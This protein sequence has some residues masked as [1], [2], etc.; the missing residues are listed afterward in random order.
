MRPTV[1]CVYADGPLLERLEPRLLLDASV[2]GPI[3]SLIDPAT[4]DQLV[5]P[6]GLSQHHLPDVD[7]PASVLLAFVLDGKGSSETAQFDLAPAIAGPGDAALALYDANGNLLMKVDA[8]S[9][10]ATPAVETMSA[11]VKSRQLY[12]LGIF[13]GP[14]P[15]LTDYDLT[16]TVG[17]QAANTAIAVDRATGLGQL[18]AASPEDTFNRPADVDCYELDLLNAGAGGTVTVTPTGQGVQVFATLFRRID[19]SQPWRPVETASDAGGNAV[20]LGLAPLMGRSLT[21]A[22]Y[23]LAVAPVGY[24]TAA[25]S[26]DIDV[27]VGPMLGPTTVEPLAA[28]DLG[29]PPPI[30]PG[31]AEAVAAGTLV[32]GTGE[33]VQFRAPAAG[34]VLL[35]LQTDF[36]PVLSVY[37]ETGADLIAVVS[38][39][40]Q[41][42]VELSLP[43]DAG[44]AYVVRA[45]DVDGNDGGAFE[46][47]VTAAYP[48]QGVVLTGAVTQIDNVPIGADQAASYYR[49]W[50]EHTTD[51]LVIGLAPAAPAGA[52]VVLVAGNLPPVEGEIAPG[53]SL[54]LPVDISG[55]YGPFDLYVAG[56]SAPA[57]ATLRIGQIAVPDEIGMGQL[58]SGKI[59]LAG[60]LAS[61]QAAGAFGDLTGVRYY[62]LLA[63]PGQ[64]TEL[65]AQGTGGAAVL[66]AHYQELGGVLQRTSF[67]LPDESGLAEL[68]RELPAEQ[69]HGIVAMSLG[70]DGVGD[71]QLA[72]DA[73]A[74]MG[75]GV[76]M[77]PDLELGNPPYG[78]VLKIRNI[79][80]EHDFEQHL[81]RTILPFNIEGVPVVTFQPANPELSAAVSVYHA[82]GT[83]IDTDEVN[84]PGQAHSFAL[85]ASIGE[86]MGETLLFRVEPIEGRPLGE[87]EY[88]LTMTVETSNPEP[89][90]LSETAWKFPHTSPH[91]VSG[92][93]SHVGTL[94]DAEEVRDIVQDQFGYGSAEGEFTSSLPYYIGLQGMGNP[95]SIDVY[96]FWAITPG[97]VAVR[98]IPLDERVNTTLKVYRARFKPDGTLD[99]L[100][101]IDGVADNQDWFP[102]DR[103]QIDAQSYINTFEVIDYDDPGSVSDPLYPPD[104]DPYG[105]QGG[106]YFVVVKNE[107]GSQGPYRIEVDVPDFPVEAR[108]LP[109][110]E[111]LPGQPVRVDLSIPEVASITDYV[112]WFPIQVPNHHDGVLDLAAAG[113][114]WDVDVFDADG[115]PLSG[116]VSHFLGTVGFFFLPPGSGTVYMRVRELG[117]NVIAFSTITLSTGLVLPGGISP[118]A[119]T[120]LVRASNM[121][122][123]SPLADGSIGATFD[124]AGRS[125]VYAFQAPI[126][127]LTVNVTPLTVDFEAEDFTSRSS[128]VDPENR[129]VVQDWKIIDAAAGAG[130]VGSGEAAGAPDGQKF[131]HASGDRYVQV[132][133]D[134][135][136]AYHVSDGS[137][138]DA[139]PAVEY[140]FQVPVSGTYN[141]QVCWGGHDGGSNTMFAS[142]VELKDGVGGAAD[143]YRFSHADY[144][145]F[146]AAGYQGAGAFEATSSSG[147]DVGATWDLTAGQTYTLRFTPREDGV[148][149][150]AFRLV[151][152]SDLELR[153]GVYVD[154]ELVV[155]DQTR[156]DAG[157]IV[158]GSMTATL[159]LPG[160]REPVPDP[161][162]AY[163]RESYADV[164]VY[165]Q[166]VAVPPG[167]GEYT[168]SVQS[169]A[170]LPMRDRNLIMDPLLATAEGTVG[171]TGGVTGQAWVRLAVPDY[172]TGDVNLQVGIVSGLHVANTPIRYDLY[173][174]EGDLVSSEMKLTTV[175]VPGSVTFLLAGVVEGNSYYLR[176]GVAN[177]ANT[178]VE[179][180][181]RV[182]LLKPTGVCPQATES[183]PS[184]LF[185][186]EASPDGRFEISFLPILPSVYVGLWV[187][188]GGRAS[189]NVSLGRVS[190][191]CVALYRAV[192]VTVGEFLVQKLQLVDYVNEVDINSFGNFDLEAWLDPGLYV[193]KAAPSNSMGSDV[194]ISG[195]LPDYV[196]E[197]VVLNP[198]DGG[199]SSLPMVNADTA[200]EGGDLEAKAKMDV[201]EHY[202]TRF[203]HVVAPAGSLE[204]MTAEA[205]HVAG[206]SGGRAYFT[207]W[208]PGS[209]GEFDLTSDKYAWPDG[210]INMSANPADDEAMVTVSEAP[211]FEE[212]WVCL[213]RFGLAGTIELWSQFV[214]PFSGTP[215]LVVELI[216]LSPN[217]G[218][219]RVDVTVRN[220]GTGP[221]FSNHA[222]YEYYDDELSQWTS[223]YRKERTLGPRASRTTTFPWPP[224]S[225][226]DD[227]RYL[228]DVD[229]EVEE[230]NERNN[231]LQREL[232]EVDPHSPTL[233]ITLADPNLDGNGTSTD[234]VFG[235]Y[236]SGVL[237][238]T[239]EVLFTGE[240]ADGGLYRMKGRYPQ[241]YMPVES[242]IGE[243]F[244]GGIEGS[245]NVVSFGYDFGNLLPTTPQ[246]TNTFRMTVFDE[247][248]LPSE[249]VVK[250]AEVMP[251]PVW[252]DNE[253]S[254]LTFDR[255]TC[256]YV[257][258]FHNS[259]IHIEGS[260]E[261]LLEYYNYGTGGDIYFIGDLPNV[262]LAEVKANARASLD[263]TAEISAQFSAHAKLTIF[264][265]NIFDETWTSSNPPT[266]DTV[267]FA[268]SLCV[269][270]ETL[271]NDALNLDAMGITFEILNKTLFAE[272][273]EATIFAYGIPGVANINAKL[274]YNLSAVL[275]LKVTVAFPMNP[276]GPPALM[277]P[278]FIGLPFSASCAITGTVEVFGLD[279]AELKGSYAVNLTPAYGLTTPAG[280]LVDFE[281]FFDY[282]DFGLSG[283]MT[284]SIGAYVLGSEVASLSPDPVNIAE[285]GHVVMN[286]AASDEP[287]WRLT[288]YP[289]SDPVGRLLS[290]P[291][292][293]LVIDPAGGEAMYVQV[294]D[295]DPD[296]DVTR[297]NLAFSWRQASVWTALTGIPDA[298]IPDAGSHVS[299]PVLALTHD[300]GLGVCP[301]V[302]VYLALAAENDPADRTRNQFFAGQDIR[303]RYFDGSTWQAEHSLT[304]DG[305]YDSE[306]AV[307]FNSTGAGVAAWT[308][309]TNPAPIG[310]DGVFDR[311]ANEIQVAAWDPAGHAWTATQTLTADAVADGMPAA[312]A[313]E[314]GTLYVV[315]LRDTTGGNEI[316]YST[317]SGGGWSPPA[318][319]PVTALPEGGRISSVAI[320]SRGPGRIDVL[321]AH[322]RQFEDYSVES[323]LYNRPSTAADF[324]LPTALEIV[325][326]NANFSHL[327]TVRA[328]DD[329]ALVAYWQQSDGVTTEVF[330]SRVGPSPAGPATWSEPIRLTSGENIEVTPSVAV[331]TDGTYQVVYE[332]QATPVPLGLSSQADPAVGVPTAG[333]VGTSH[334]ELLPELG[335]LREM[336]FPYATKAASGAECVATARI[337]NRGPAGDSVLIEYIEYRAAAGGPVVVGSETILL[338]PG[339]E[340]EIAHPFTVAAGLV[341]YSIRLTAVGGAEAV[342]N[343]DNVSSAELEGLPDLTVTSVVLSNPHPQAGETLIVTSTVRNLSDQPIGAFSVQ[344]YEGDPTAE[345]L[346]TNLVETQTVGSLGPGASIAVMSS[347]TVPAG[348]NGY[349]LTGLADA[350]DE[351]AEAVEFNNHGQAFVIVRA[352]AVVGQAITTTVLDYTG[353][354]NVQVT[355]QVANE[356][357]AGLTDVPAQLLW[358]WNDG[359]FCQIGTVN[360]PSLPAGDT[361]EVQWLAPGW[362]GENRYLVVVDPAMGLPETNRANN[363]A[364]TLLRLQGLADLEVDDVKLN[365]DAPAQNDPLRVSAVIHNTG[366][367]TARNVLVEVFADMA[368]PGR[369]LIGQTTVQ[370]LLPLSATPVVIPIDTSRLIGA[371]DLWV[372]VDRLE[373]ILELSDLNNEECLQVD[374]YADTTAPVVAATTFNDGVTNWAEVGAIAFTFYENVEV[375]A[376]AL[377]IGSDTAGDDV[378]I[379][380]A[381]FTYDEA[382]FTARWDLRDLTLPVGRYTATLSEDYVRDIPGHM[383]DG[384]ED[385]EEGGD[386]RESFLVTFPGDADVDGNVDFL[387]Y[388]IYKRNAGTGSGA[389]WYDADANGDGAVDGAD[390][391]IIED[392]FGEFME[393][394]SQKQADS[395]DPNGDGNGDSPENAP[396]EGSV[397][398]PVLPSLPAASVAEAA[399]DWDA[400]YPVHPAGAE[401]RSG[402]R[403]NLPRDAFAEAVASLLPAGYRPT[404]SGPVAAFAR[405]RPAGRVI[406]PAALRRGAVAA[407]GT[408]LRAAS[409]VLTIRRDTAALEAPGGAT[410]A[411][412][413]GVGDLLDVLRL[414]KLLPWAD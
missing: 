110:V 127:P 211:P 187:G 163:D 114:F 28:M 8:D 131:A 42:T 87:G 294:V 239:T 351:I 45:G 209:D 70:F 91:F 224:K 41:N 284:A 383:L 122:P 171:G 347:W 128:G 80:L 249:E 352:D 343:A 180:T 144:G 335:F 314:N 44:I 141:L 334:V 69:L 276:F 201:L 54:V 368:S 162:Y 306:P 149:V 63:E 198:Q 113:G 32:A 297:N 244:S 318:A 120:L 167:G 282:S 305:L 219:T 129:D 344:L 99:Y 381:P 353:A 202:R 232:S 288:A 399:E 338:G 125:S 6:P 246:N 52:K 138:V 20:T 274:S 245:H 337:V 402:S 263:P 223:S 56:T 291:R 240:D 159:A 26:Y 153:W 39:T 36:Q 341:D 233:T 102:A 27:A 312:F 13:F 14:S 199:N 375:E 82:D 389:T 94:P 356:G 327:R 43:V 195:D 92:D 271:E 280:T 67:Q 229:H 22:E 330:A 242:Q 62:Q 58:A 134:V 372:V 174:M 115:Q 251:F 222:R 51:V 188:S 346:P 9:L 268:F 315:W 290:D 332:S 225:P 262:L 227:V 303:W 373:H 81:W 366:I 48:P 409:D 413:D 256:E 213:N 395:G 287:E 123:T 34:T 173:D 175:A 214:V 320:G 279:V 37:D 197:E 329:G 272:K 400:T 179:L 130:D 15:P 410:A 277:S 310:E 264:G 121:L 100:G 53:E 377:T 74:P 61:T 254:S 336:A 387:D 258:A 261:D 139:G 106:M 321:L 96:R 295:V 331:D 192:L 161:E 407:A 354:D 19:G 79:V 90:I 296:P 206:G 236:I 35:T 390:L 17:P 365:S 278:T 391:Q 348:S 405:L 324:A 145:D 380:D 57:V 414:S 133:P 168:V 72:V 135:G 273:G 136:N 189:F 362:A 252:L 84:S 231:G 328:A 396:V 394:K 205:L 30:V 177:S 228:T 97:P 107:E 10:V 140:E 49:F 241:N 238:V 25:G 154:G 281:D 146:G 300:G 267:K 412:L 83:P 104:T 342:G 298:G 220:V 111:D 170:A 108:Y 117:E 257:L 403:L 259:L 292:P 33:L 40:W 215:D 137:Q 234:G 359:E 248:G 382:T 411:S 132:L 208:A 164:S 308:H 88:T 38:R 363:F 370:E 398:E 406:R 299:N 124:A 216:E 29:T 66:V 157:G 165:V 77:V 408:R 194:C 260:I 385:G 275:K 46:L 2:I 301:A 339:S 155:W 31:I 203:F 286:A 355:A 397:G 304:S 364:Q 185:R 166:S 217:H 401:R 176:A 374:F 218:E 196:P 186:T 18:Q 221:A 404:A 93:G 323:R 76:G 158:P 302:V 386:Y 283:N 235:R 361:T 210:Q 47:A 86:L 71:V 190:S 384:D 319:L 255:G 269:D 116:S 23:L 316:L 184:L 204:D 313:D 325:A 172:I 112:G 78:W 357:R 143:W 109:S 193:I 85:S 95:G 181:A 55:R 200:A 24:N 156:F 73:P 16:V 345:Y 64:I 378:D 182:G 103:T 183:F 350:D 230:L 50:P 142:V 68:E 311:S 89:F 367:D 1:L 226:E 266:G 4:A 65:S 265:R 59:D 119:T 309:N 253:E 126:G 60:E 11:Q 250:I 75:V 340:Y 317:H 7:G 101:E 393:A 388:L 152:V 3:P 169:A 207:V 293:N 376:E 379:H 270:G 5:L 307:A 369:I 322:S 98:T 326:E 160:L 12:V 150:D 118:P 285:G 360:I 178:M 212:F 392:N 21:D 349:L 191:P 289:G 243:F 247:Y 358:S 237:G 151:L 147:G 105:T 371:V 333:S 148:A